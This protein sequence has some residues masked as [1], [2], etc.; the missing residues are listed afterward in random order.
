MI[1]NPLFGLASSPSTSICL[2][3]LENKEQQLIL[4]HPYIQKQG[5]SHR[6]WLPPH[7][8]GRHYPHTRESSG[9]IAIAALQSYPPDDQG[10]RSAALPATVINTLLHRSSKTNHTFWMSHS[11]MKPISDMLRKCPSPCN[12]LLLGLCPMRLFFGEP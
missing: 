9:I 6:L 2:C 7:P 12:L 4:L 8:G 11:E 5:G 3:L 10:W 1:Q